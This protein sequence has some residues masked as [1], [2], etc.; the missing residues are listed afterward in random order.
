MWAMPDPARQIETLRALRSRPER[1]LRVGD[2]I[3]RTLKEN[4]QRQ[5]R[6][7]QLIDLWEE[8]VPRDLAAKTVIEH[9]RAGVLHVTVDSSATAY[10]LD[11]QL[12]EGLEALLRSRYRGTLVR[13]KV[14][15]GAA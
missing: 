8:L 15:V 4:S 2:L 3:K 7:G 11:R 13:V 5:K 6:L 9:L 1:D 10:E 12:R 14:K